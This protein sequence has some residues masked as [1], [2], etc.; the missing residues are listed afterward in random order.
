MD[1]RAD[2]QTDGWM[3]GRTDGRTDGRMD[4]WMKYFLTLFEKSTI[5][6]SARTGIAGLV[7]SGLVYDSAVYP[8]LAD[9]PLHED[10][11]SCG[12]GARAACEATYFRCADGRCIPGRWRCDFEDDCG[13]L[14]DEQ[15]CTPR[16]CSETEFRCANGECIRGLLRCSGGPECADGSD[17]V[18]CAPACA[19]RARPCRT[20][21]Q[22][23]LR[24][25]LD[26]SDEESC[27]ASPAAAAAC[28]ARLACGGAACAPAA[29]RCDGRRDCAAGEDEARCDR[30][31]CPPPMFRCGNNSCVP[32]S[33]LCDGFRDCDDGSDENE[34]ACS[35]R[36]PESLCEQDEQMCGDGR[37]VPSGAACDTG[38]YYTIDDRIAKWLE[39][40]TTKLE[41]PGS[42]LAGA[43]ICLVPMA[44]YIRDPISCT[45]DPVSRLPRQVW[46]LYWT[47]WNDSNPRIQR[48]YSSGRELQTIIS[49]DILMPNGLAI[50][51][52]T[53][54][55]FWADAR[56][57]KIERCLLDGSHRHIGAVRRGAPFDVAACRGWVFWSDWV[58]RGVLRADGRGG[59][60]R[61]LRKDLPRPMG[62]VCVTPTPDLLGWMDG[63]SKWKKLVEPIDMSIGSPDPCATLNGGCAEICTKSSGGVPGPELL[64]PVNTHCPDG[65]FACAE[66]E[67]IPEELVCDG[68]PNCGPGDASDED[69]YYC[70]S[71][72]CPADTVSCGAGGRC[73]RAG[74]LCDGVDDCDDGSDETVCDCPDT[75]FRCDDGTCVALSARCSGSGGVRGRVGRGRLR[76]QRVRGA[77]RRRA[78]VRRGRRLLPAAVAL[79]RRARLPR[80]G[81]R[82]RLQPR[83]TTHAGRRRAAVRRGR[84]LL[85]AAVGLRRRA[86][87]PRRGGRGRLQP[88]LT[89]TLG[90]G[91]LPWRRG[92]RLLPAAVAL[93]RRARLP[94]RGGRGRLQPRSVTLH[95]QTD[96]TRWARRRAAV[97]RGRRLLPA[98]VAL[99]RRARL[100]R[101]GGR[102]RLQPRLTTHA[103]RR[104]AAVRRGRRLLPAAVALRRRARLPRRGGRGRLQPRLTTH[105]GRRR[106]A[107]RRG[108]R[109]L[110]AAVALRRRARLP[111]RA[112]EAGCS[113]TD[114]TRWAPARCRAARAAAATCRS[115]A[116]TA[117]PT[118]PTGRTRPAAAP[119]DH[120][121]WAPARCRAARAAA[122]TCRSGAATARPTAPTGRTRPAAAPTDHTRW[123]PARCRA[124]RAAA[125]TCRSGA[126]TA[127]PT[128]RRGGRGRLQ[129][130]SVTLHRQTDHTRWAPARCRA[131]RARCYYRRS[132]AATGARLP[133]R[134]GRGRLQP[135]SVTLH[136]QTD[137]TRCPRAA[138]GWRSINLGG[139]PSTGRDE[140]QFSCSTE[141]IE[142][143][144]L[145]WRCDGRVDCSDGSD[146]LMHCGHKNT[147]ACTPD[148]FSCG[149]LCIRSAARCDGVADCQFAED[150]ADC[151][152][153]P[154]AFRCAAERTCLHEVRG[155]AIELL[156][157]IPAYVSLTYIGCD[158]DDNNASNLRDYTATAT[159]TARTGP[160]S[161]WL[162]ARG[163]PPRTASAPTPA[164]NPC[165]EPGALY[166]AG[167]C[168]SPELVCDG[169]DHCLDGLGEGAGS[170][171]DPFMCYV[172]LGVR[173]GEWQCSNRACVPRAA[174]CDSRD[175]CGDYSDECGAVSLATLITDVEL[176]SNRQPALSVPVMS[177]VVSGY[178]N[179]CMIRN[180]GCPHN[181]TELPV[182]AR[183]L[184][185]RGLAAS[186]PRL[187]RRGRVRRGRALRP[188]LQRRAGAGKQKCMKMYVLSPADAGTT[189]A[190]S[191]FPTREEP[192]Q[193]IELWEKENQRQIIVNCSRNT[194][195][196]FVCSCENGYKLM[197][198]GVS[199]A[200]ISNEPASLIFTNRYYIRRVS[201]D[202]AH[203]SSLLI[204]NL[205][206]AVALD[207]EWE[208]RCLY[209]SDVTRL[210]S[211]IKRA[212]REP[213]QELSHYQ[214]LHGATLQNPDGLAVDWVAGNVYWCDKGT[215]TLEV[216]RT[217]GT[218]R[219]V[220]IRTGLQEPR[221]LAL[222]PARGTIYWSDWGMSPH[223]GRAGMD[224][225][226]RTILISAGLGWPN[227][228][229][230]YFADAR[231][232]YIAVADLDGKRV[233]V[234][235]SRDRMPWLRLH[236]VFALTVWEGRV[237]WSDW[238]TR[239][240]ESCRRRPNPHYKANAT[241]DKSAGGAYECK[242]V[243]LTVHKPMDLR[244]H[245]P[246]RQPP[247][248]EL[249]AL[250]AQLNCSGLC[251]LTPATESQPAGARCECPEHFVLAADG[252]SCSPNCTSAHFVCASTLKCIPFWWRCDTQDDCGDGSDE[253]ASCPSFRC[254]PG[255]FQCGGGGRCLHPALICDATNHCADGSDERDCDTFTCL[256]SQLKCAGNATA[257]TAAR[258]V[259]A[260]A[261]CDG[262]RDCPSGDDERDCPPR[263]C[264]PDHFMCGDGS[265]VPDVWVCDTDADCADGADEGAHCAARTCPP[266]HFRCASGRCIPREWLCDAEADCPLHEDEASCGTG[267]R[268]ACE[269][270]YFRCADGRC[271]PGRWRCDFED[272]CG[273]LS[274]EQ[275][276]TPRNCSETEF[277]AV[278]IKIALFA[279]QWM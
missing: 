230:L 106:A 35:R 135:R 180:G 278:Q 129:P 40:L 44:M 227:A 57:D 72:S 63:G 66:G 100:P 71:R 134:G 172:P 176:T 154:R 105:A 14:S 158:D 138:P 185:P 41:V 150:E 28:G 223:I 261:R 221:A 196:S 246:A 235:F 208:R 13:D 83:L 179:E 173:G 102:G 86:R 65:Q 122:A 19:A 50:E 38:Q 94:R 75:Q 249:T 53:R 188:P 80:R 272:D 82:G 116:A 97:R 248:P 184:V 205:T 33:L 18:G 253:P 121:R 69:L 77:G 123:A 201:L 161:P 17:E 95:R 29:W 96:H 27:E 228:L 101:R 120:T 103:G 279:M 166:C 169:R 191:K 62:L 265:C 131:A 244:V 274:D 79:R 233:R 236:H 255:Q 142:C 260:A 211:S 99:R 31:A 232:D 76:A 55:L 147:T 32:P 199:C 168:L 238:E 270:T 34:H 51:H 170:D 89:H 127:R 165:A 206:N 20:P 146:E 52:T 193:R 110:P 243:A 164:L 42:I 5:Q 139:R 183:V 137:R 155:R 256:S 30:Y 197:E 258:C 240:V 251:L 141:G 125:A 112:D 113:P 133:R 36:S 54:M 207:M 7:L 12:T 98:A 157:S 163:P 88:R 10:E 111:R 107:V 67:C 87:L 3:E 217:D 61:A 15:N 46:R 73:V 21:P 264:K 160:T 242:T 266:R 143:I 215:D 43:D 245:H 11:A 90:A 237:Y 60:A 198:D 47:N 204:H 214:I 117:R 189:P 39:N 68:I 148:E 271:I 186:A 276:C 219:R 247:A 132:G 175:D 108:R 85:P 119:T 156:I 229:V 263:S 56:L 234:L 252:R 167:R 195:G 171:E 145:T 84:R 115:G 81:G 93:R 203:A 124:A 222:H 136:R 178:I 104:R 74:A 59:G 151:A 220:L 262:V 269:A 194:I 259:P 241:E 25:L 254:S 8:E 181:C 275:N 24:G 45:V 22:C 149:S 202:E 239:A 91:A 153:A 218:H 64:P 140:D 118:A 250:C 225:S 277:R 213:G 267:A 1:G 78:A 109:L 144:P 92:R 49:K 273:D 159:R 2:G 26:G 4:G 6:A 130:R 268:A 231:E 23:V 187:R 216:S 58:G 114:H 16:N 70:T 177:S 224:G 226:A 37:C 210:G 190:G 212:C 126:A 162:R 200:P 9:C 48:A 174:L 257:G 182:G 152:C 192:T 209:W 128:A